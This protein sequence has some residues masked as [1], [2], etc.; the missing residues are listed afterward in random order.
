ELAD[1]LADVDLVVVEN[2]LTIPMNVGASLALAGVLRG[3]PALIHH[4]DPP[5]QRPRY[6]HVRALPVDDAAWRHVTINRLTERQFAERGFAATTI[7][8]GIDVDRPEGERTLFRRRLDMD[9]RPLLL[10]PVR[11]VARKDVPAALRLAE[12]TGGTYWLTGVAEE[13]YA[14]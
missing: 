2:A 4:H 14:A 5:W 11:A 7:Y 8:N 12:A 6:A 10:H 9:D 13:G 1:A 3:R